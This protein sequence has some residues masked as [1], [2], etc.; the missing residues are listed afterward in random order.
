MSQAQDSDGLVQ[1]DG[2]TDD[3]FTARVEDW[4]F[5]PQDAGLDPDDECEGAP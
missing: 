5:G 4:M 1:G 2:E 3:E